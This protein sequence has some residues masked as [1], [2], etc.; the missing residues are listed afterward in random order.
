MKI[1]TY[2]DSKRIQDLWHVLADSAKASPHTA[3]LY[4]AVLRELRAGVP[5][6]TTIARV[7]RAG[8]SHDTTI[9]RMGRAGVSHDTTIT[10]AD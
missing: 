5:H 4:L 9:A 6:E 2:P 1:N 8:V 3:P 10:G 7:G